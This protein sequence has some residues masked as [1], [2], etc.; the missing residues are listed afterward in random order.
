MTNVIVAFSKLEDAKSIKNILMRSGFSVVAVC[1]SGSQ[2]ISSLDGLNG[3]IIV[4]GY[5][6]KDMLFRQLHDDLPENFKLLLVA[7]PSRCC[8]SIPEDI[9]CL[10]MPL[11]IHDF[12]DTVDMMLQAQIKRRKHHQKTKRSEDEVTLIHKAKVLLMERNNMTESEAHRYI[13][14]CSMDSGTNMTETAHMVI[15]LINL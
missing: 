4:S 3:G 12:I 2:A 5:R 1:T 7:P 11:K 15:S 10:T 6:F 9:V 8:G 14:K 13:Q